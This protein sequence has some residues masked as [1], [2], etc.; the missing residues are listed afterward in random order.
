M[1]GEYVGGGNIRDG[2]AR[3]EDVAVLDE[4]F[5]L[6]G[7]GVGEGLE[8]FQLDGV[9]VLEHLVVVTVFVEDHVDG[10][11]DILGDGGLFVLC[12]LVEHV[13]GRFSF[14]AERLASEAEFL[15]GEL[16]RL[17]VEHKNSHVGI[18]LDVVVVFGLGAVQ[19]HGG[20][21]LLAD[22]AF[23]EQV[24]VNV[25]VVEGLD[26]GHQFQALLAQVYDGRADKYFD[27][28]HWWKLLGWMLLYI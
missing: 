25:L 3:E 26:E 23:D 10:M 13:N 4:Q 1:V 18:V 8:E 16:T 11:F 9:G 12:R 27:S 2:L 5:G 14:G 24:S 20:V 6:A 7:K 28:F 22:V 15:Q 17:A 19:A 21:R